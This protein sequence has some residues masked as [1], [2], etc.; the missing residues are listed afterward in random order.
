MV[1]KMKLDTLTVDLIKE[2]EYIIGKNVYN[3]A[4]KIMKPTKMA[5]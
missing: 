5:T 1:I 4:T 3:K 2:L